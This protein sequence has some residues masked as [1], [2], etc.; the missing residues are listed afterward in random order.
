MLRLVH[1]RKEGQ[2]SARKIKKSASLF[3]T[4]E[5]ADRI[6]ATI[7]TLRVAFGGWDVLAEVTGV[8]QTTL[9]MIAHRRSPGSYGVAI[10]LARAAGIPVE[11]I[12]R[13]GVQEAGKCPVC[14]RKGPR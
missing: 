2:V 9:E 6:R 5:E 10:A 3:P 7:R 1:P 13:P 14:G 12:L 8:K 11:Q 4:A